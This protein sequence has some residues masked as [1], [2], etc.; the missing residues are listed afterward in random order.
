MSVDSQANTDVSN[1]PQSLILIRK[2]LLVSLHVKGKHL[3]SSFGVGVDIFFFF[4]NLFICYLYVVLGIE[5]RACACQASTGLHPIHMGLF[6]N[7]FRKCENV[8]DVR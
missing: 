2:Y 1:L 7:V 8:L 4:T 6:F 3:M 5:L